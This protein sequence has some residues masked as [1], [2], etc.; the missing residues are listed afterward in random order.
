MAKAKAV[1]CSACTVAWN[2][3]V[4]HPEGTPCPKGA[5]TGEQDAQVVQPATVHTPTTIN[6]YAMPAKM[7]AVW[8]A[9][10]KQNPAPNFMFIGPPG[11]GKTDGGECLAAMD[12]YEHLK[13]DCASMTDPVDWFGVREIVVEDGVAVTYY[14]PS[15]FIETIQRRSVINLDEINRIPDA[16]RQVL[17]PLLDASRAVLN[18][19]DGKI[20]Q[21]H[22]ECV[23]LMTGNV[24]L[25]FT[26]TSA[27]D[28][29]FTSRAAILN[30]DYVDEDVERGILRH[31]AGASEQLATQL[32]KFAVD[33]RE[34]A[35]VD[36]DWPTVSTR[37]LMNVC[38][39]VSDGLDTTT[40]LEICVFNG[41]SSEGGASSIQ[42][43]ML[44]LWAALGG[45]Q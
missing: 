1:A 16:V 32:V 24:G 33:V 36:P 9:G 38:H 30:V 21:R 29:A 17:L 12:G 5:A 4:F 37:E 27:I 23:I 14:R 41:A 3:P 7:L 11:S 34:K 35:K 6:G 22:P 18:P 20:V 8:I 31:K 43:A 39:F 25:R 28:P 42:S 45:T 19:L 40:A 2:L 26:G 15:Q 44:I 10:V 13:V